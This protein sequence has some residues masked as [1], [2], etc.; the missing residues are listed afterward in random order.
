MAKQI[1][2]IRLRPSSTDYETWEKTTA[3]LGVPSNGKTEPSKLVLDLLG[4]NMEE[5]K[6][7]LVV[8]I[9]FDQT[10]INWDVEEYGWGGYFYTGFFNYIQ[11]VVDR[12]KELQSEGAVLHICTLRGPT[13]FWPGDKTYK[14]DEH[15]KDLERDYGLQFFSVEYT[16]GGA[17]NPFLSRVGATHFFEDNDNNICQAVQFVKGC[18]C[19]LVKERKTIIKNVLL[20]ELIQSD[21]VE[22]LEHDEG[23]ELK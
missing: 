1:K 2:E 20:D 18:Q 4:L 19:V 16:N 11:P 13:C 6:Q 10:I 5:K 21:M 17:K 12:L 15:I 8:C 7:N 9:D 22:V 14:I 23:K 3:A